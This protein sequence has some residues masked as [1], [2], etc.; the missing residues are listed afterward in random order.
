MSLK[1]KKLSHQDDSCS[2]QH[3]QLSSENHSS[4]NNN[5]NNSQQQAGLV[6]D[7]LILIGSFMEIIDIIKSMSGVCKYWNEVCD[8]D[9]LW[10]GLFHRELGSVDW[11]ISKLNKNLQQSASSGGTAMKRILRPVAHNR[12][13]GG[14]NYEKRYF[15]FDED[16]AGEDDD[17]VDDDEVMNGNEKKDVGVLKKTSL[18]RSIEEGKQT[19]IS[20]DVLKEVLEDCYGV[21]R[22]W[23]SLFKVVAAMIPIQ[24]YKLMTEKQII[25]PLDNVTPMVSS[26]KKDDDDDDDDE[27]EDYDEDDEADNQEE[28]DQ[29]DEEKEKKSANQKP[30]DDFF[31][32]D[33]MFKGKKSEEA[34][35]HLISKNY[36]Y[37]TVRLEQ[38]L[39][40][41]FGSELENATL[42]QQALYVDIKTHKLAV[43]LSIFDR[44]GIILNYFG[45]DSNATEK[46][47]NKITGQLA[48]H[49]QN[50]TNYVLSKKTRPALPR[51]PYVTECD[52]MCVGLTKSHH[53]ISILKF[54]YSVLCEQ[55]DS[56]YQPDSVHHNEENIKKA[57]DEEEENN[58]VND[59][60][61]GEERESDLPKQL[62]L[63]PENHHGVVDFG[64]LIFTFIM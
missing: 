39:D 54:C 38:I 24:S 30:K 51:T 29:S 18:K 47:L 48:I 62:T 49:A 46:Y 57:N 53:T 35:E 3:Q 44:H 22:F 58:D 6:S 28:D 20:L 37:F 55:E 43:I 63:H 10:K 45:S 64:M 5:R 60:N 8:G 4:N 7:T 12:E 21:N 14:L 31:K 1:K 9:A 52:T 19:I 15:G 36:C 2:I 17:N 40:V 59:D 25:Q 33:F 13:D 50:I 56:I 34:T 41:I 26:K 27:D 61:D 42:L 32:R 16:S 23:L 11:L